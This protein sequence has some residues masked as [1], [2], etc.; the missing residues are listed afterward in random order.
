MYASTSGWR[1]PCRRATP[2]WRS[3]PFTRVTTVRLSRSSGGVLT[4]SPTGQNVSKPLAR[5]HCDRRTSADRARSR[6]SRPR[7][8]ESRRVPR[9][10]DR[11]TDRLADD[12]A[13]L[14]FVLDLRR[15]RREHD[16]LAVRDHAR[17]RLE[18]DQRLLRDLVA[19]LLGVIAVVAADADDLSG[20]D[21][22]R[23]LAVADA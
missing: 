23:V 8:P 9:S 11:A 13:D 7:C 15:L 4:G 5:V 20:T 6:R 22:Q 2:R 18:K 17:R 16:G 12:D 1:T 19:D 14:P 10:S 3:T 21:S